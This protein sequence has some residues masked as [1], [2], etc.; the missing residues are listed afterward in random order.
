MTVDVE[1]SVTRKFVVCS[2]GKVDCEVPIPVGKF[3]G[4]IV[5]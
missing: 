2:L 5:E 1:K 4:V 3:I